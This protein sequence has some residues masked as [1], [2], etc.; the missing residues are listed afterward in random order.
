M[1][2]IFKRRKKMGLFDTLSKQLSEKSTAAKLGESV[3]VSPEKVQ[4]LTEI[5]LPTLLQGLLKNSSTPEGAASLAKALD[6][7]KNDNVSNITSFL[8]G[9]NKDD[10]V[11]MLSH[12]FSG[13]EKQ[14]EKSLA[15]ETGLKTNQVAGLLSQLAPLLMG[16]LGQE[17]KK[18][19]LDASGI[20][21]LLSNVA[22]Q[23]D[24]GMMGMAA[25]FLDSN[26]DGNIIDD[27]GNLFGKIF[28]K[29]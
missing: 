18:E 17:K 9:V 3:G 6:Q 12:I 24:S 29:K 10:G 15:K 8:N 20:A 7:H 23:G 25:N 13:K 1:L 22:S 4:K 21:G 28:K 26:K 2:L 19:N 16:F 27:V 11:N 14:V 5:G